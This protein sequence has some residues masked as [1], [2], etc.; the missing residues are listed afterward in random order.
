MSD[1]SLGNQNFLIVMDTMLP[2]L[3]DHIYKLQLTMQG[4]QTGSTWLT[5]DSN[6]TNQYSGS[7]VLPSSQFEQI[8]LTNVQFTQQGDMTFTLMITASNISVAVGSALKTI[9]SS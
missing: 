8:N 2:K 6:W 5:I 1:N 7:V 4:T 9:L 3:Q